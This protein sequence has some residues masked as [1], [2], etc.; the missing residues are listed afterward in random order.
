MSSSVPSSVAAETLAEAAA[1]WN[2]HDV[3]SLVPFMTGE[4]MFEILAGPQACG[5]RH[6]SRDISETV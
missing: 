2:R 6:V 4:C 1:A 3:D 5:S